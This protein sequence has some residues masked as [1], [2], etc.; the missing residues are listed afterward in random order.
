MKRLFLVDVSSMFFR[1][2]YAIRQLSSSKGLPTNALYGFLAMTVKLLREERPD[3]LAY[4]FDRPEPS[5]RREIYS[6]YKA[7]RSEMPDDLV[8]Q[9]PYVRQLTEALGIPLLEKTRFEADDLIGTLAHLGAVHE[10]EV[11]IVSGDKDFSQLIRPGISMLDTMKDVHYDRDKVIEKWGVAPH[12]FIDYLALVGDASDN[13]PG[14]KGIGP[15]TAVQLL[16]QFESLDGIYSNLEKIEKKNLKE[17][18][19]NAKTEA[20]LSR[21]LVT[22]DQNVELNVKPED[23]LLKKVQREKL[24]QILQELDFRSFEKNLLGPTDSQQTIVLSTTDSTAKQNESQLSQLSQSLSGIRQINEVHLTMSQWAELLPPHQMLWG[25]TS[26]RGFYLAHKNTVYIIDEGLSNLAEVINHKQIS[27]CGFDLKNVWKEIAGDLTHPKAAVDLMLS[28]QLTQ[29]GSDETFEACYQRHIGEKLSEFLSP[30]QLYGAH[31]K[32]KEALDQRVKE[33]NGEQILDTM[34]LPLVSVLY[35]MEK[36][37]IR[38]DSQTLS[39]QSAKLASEIGTVGSEIFALAKTTFN[40]LSPK[41]LAEVL[42]EKLN[43]PTG[44]KIKTGYSTD[45][46]VLVKL[47]ADYPICE[48]ILNYRELCKLKSTYVDVL[49]LLINKNTGRVHTTFNQTGTVTGRLSSVNPNLQNIP[50]R[51]ERG[52]RVRQAFIADPGHQ[53]LSADYSQI[54]LRVLAQIS[55]D[56]AL[57]EAFENQLDI[58]SAT[59]ARVFHVRLEEVTAEMR[60][61]AKAVNFGIAYGQGAYGLALSL[62]KTQQEA[63]DIIKEYFCRYPK[64]QDYMVEV[65]ERAKATGYVETLFGRRRYL[66]EL[67]SKNSNTK[68]FGERAAINM[69]IQ[70]TASDLVKLAMIEMDRKLKVNMLLQVHDELL[71]EIPEAQIHEMQKPICDIMEKV[72]VTNLSRA[73]HCHLTDKTQEK[74]VPFT[75]HMGIGKNWEEAH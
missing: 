62:G 70:G 45:N 35:A 58:H 73:T 9:I 34:D 7:N 66:P 15:K 11:V 67:Q 26:N 13:I 38:I 27:W 32:L 69:P 53:F 57:C 25:W 75:V 3:Y 72:L 5:F 12:Q 71:F 16:T 51:T 19:R 63:S 10:M 22:I 41:Q 43:M 48:K 49:P 64:V 1:A 44:K 47:A 55:Q 6:E 68:K 30:T 24:L 21:Q 46:E 31:L 28:A 42:F 60:R 37:G 50:I 2:F 65:V 8:P 61:T 20:Y 23:L 18:L 14:V 29:T 33:V 52:L 4:C 54:D 17:K 56:P 40:I 36:R 74:V 39:A 59:A